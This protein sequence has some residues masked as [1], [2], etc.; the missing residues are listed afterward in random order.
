ML[1]YCFVLEQAQGKLCLSVRDTGKTPSPMASIRFISR[2]FLKQMYV[3]DFVLTCW[4]LVHC[5]Y[6]LRAILCRDYMRKIRNIRISAVLRCYAFFWGGGVLFYRH[7][8]IMHL[9]HLHRSNNRSKWGPWRGDRYAVT[10]RRRL[11][12]TNEAQR[13]RR[14]KVPSVLWRLKSLSKCSVR[15]SG[16]SGTEFR[17]QDHSNTE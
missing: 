8:V 15:I 4:Q 13:T 1:R 3:V 10:K 16:V 7:F 5:E 12:P 6:F 14:R 11:P 2:N 9:S 17:N